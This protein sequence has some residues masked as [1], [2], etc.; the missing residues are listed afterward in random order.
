MSVSRNYPDLILYRRL[1]AEARPYWAH[2]VILFFLYLLATPLTLLN[3]LPLKIAVDSVIG[4]QPLPAWLDQIAPS[5]ITEST[6]S[7]LIFSVG[8]L[9]VIALLISLQ[10]L[11]TWMLQAYTGEKLLLRF[12]A[13][14]FRHIQKLSFIHHDNK[15]SMDSLYRI[16]NDTTAIQNTVAGFIPLVSGCVTLLGMI[17]VTSVIDWQLALV[18]L[19][20]VP[21]LILFTNLSR[22]FVRRQWFELKEHESSAMSVVQETLGA[23]RVVKAFGK[24][25]HQSKHFSNRSEKVVRDQINVALTEGGFDLLIGVTLGVGTAAVLLIGVRHVEAGILTLGDLLLVMAYLAQLYAPLATISKTVTQLQ[26]S[27]ASAER[28]FSILDQEVEVKELR[29]PVR[30][31]RATGSIEIRDLCFGYEPGRE[32]LHDISFR[33]DPGTRVGILGTTG[34]GK[35]T[36]VNMLLRFYDPDKGRILLDDIDIREYKLADL[37]KQFAMVLQEPVL[38]SA[39][40]AE[41]IS[42]S[43]PDA[44]FESIRQAAHAANAHNFISNL[45]KD[46][47]TVVGE[48]GMRLSGGERQRISLA[49]AFLKDAPMLILDEPTSSVDTATETV[50]MEAMDRLMEGRTTFMIAHRLSTLENCD[51]W[52]RLE[53]GKP[54][55]VFTTLPLVG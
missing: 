42:Y 1:L 48:R 37:R 22:R 40:I 44:S 46:Y 32:V 5:T 13:R 27:L 36:L 23:L 41:N 6:S 21:L 8:F 31:K 29:D 34:S 52:V 19:A 38:F 51:L 18:A 16:Q 53:C 11:G 14:L 4:S 45:P 24:E 35:T 12:R 43:D 7:L 33:V 50:I 30:I 39:S 3:P 49:R 54:V 20:I 2:I 9:I 17:W 28:V 55:R 15:G 26:S 10:A 25:D 47:D